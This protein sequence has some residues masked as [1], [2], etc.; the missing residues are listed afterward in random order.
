MARYIDDTAL[1]VINQ[2]IQSNNREIVSIIFGLNLNQPNDNQ[3]YS[4]NAVYGSIINKS[5]SSSSYGLTPWGAFS[6][7]QKTIKDQ[8]VEKIKSRTNIKERFQAIEFMIELC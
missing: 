7:N 3:Q 5:N 1:K 6:S 2:L 8:I 4:N